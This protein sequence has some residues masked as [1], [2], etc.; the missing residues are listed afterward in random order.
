MTS[1][2]NTLL[3]MSLLSMELCWAIPAHAFT[4]ATEWTQI[5]NYG[6][7]L[8]NASN[9]ITMITNEVQQLQAAQQNLVN[10]PS[11]L[12]TGAVAPYQNQSAQAQQYLTQLQSTQSAY[13]QAQQMLQNRI[14]EGTALGASPEQYL[15]MEAQLAQQKGGMYQA[16]YQND[17]NTLQ[18]VSTRSA[19]LQ[20]MSN[21][22]PSSGTVDGLDKL[23]TTLTMVAGESMTLNKQ[24]AAASAQTHA[25][26][27]SDNQQQQASLAHQ[28]QLT[29]QSQQIASQ[30]QA[31]LQNSSQQLSAQASTPSGYNQQQI[32]HNAWQQLN[33]NTVNSH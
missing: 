10:A 11:S 6:Q 20:T 15:A 18:D 2:L 24:M 21:N 12:I 7:L 8:Q 27:M 28:Q 32:E 33:Q 13:Q 3:A 9:E 22:L 17:L 5:L 25:Q 31:D 1:K 16:A 23:N 26:Q 29:A 30:I 19:A 4:W 14:A